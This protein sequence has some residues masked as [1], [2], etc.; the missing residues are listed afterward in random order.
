MRIFFVINIKLSFKLFNLLPNHLRK[1]EDVEST[2]QQLIRIA[3]GS[4]LKLRSKFTSN[5]FHEGKLQEKP[6]LIELVGLSQHHIQLHADIVDYT[7]LSLQDLYYN[8]PVIR[9]SES[10]MVINTMKFEF[11]DS[12]MREYPIMKNDDFVMQLEFDAS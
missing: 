12:Q 5:I 6:K 8:R 9:D 4:V 2:D 7:K 3:K 11:F 10:N 1:D